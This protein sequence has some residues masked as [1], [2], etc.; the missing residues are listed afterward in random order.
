MTVLS[1]LK[2]TTGAGKVL[3]VL[4]FSWC[5]RAASRRWSANRIRTARGAAI[6]KQ[7]VGYF[8]PLAIRGQISRP[9]RGV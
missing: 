9:V 2:Q 8:C 6:S 3:L 4:T 5:G 7:C 1:V